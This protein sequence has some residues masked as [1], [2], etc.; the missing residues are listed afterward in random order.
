MFI[1]SP[2]IGHECCFPL[3]AMMNTAAMNIL[4]MDIHFHF[5]WVNS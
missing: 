1:H 3:E 5:P 2:I 4:F